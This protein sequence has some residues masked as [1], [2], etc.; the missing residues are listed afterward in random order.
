M[1]PN[2]YI[3][4]LKRTI[5]FSAV[6]HLSILLGYALFTN[7]FKILNLYNILDLEFI[8]PNILN[9]SFS[10]ISSLIVLIII[11]ILFLL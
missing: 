4:A 2:K 8:F 10:D 7:N 11:Y 9:G 5:L 6:V 3:K 1:K